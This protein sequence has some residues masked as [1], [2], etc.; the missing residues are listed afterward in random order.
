MQTRS[1]GA[2][3]SPASQ[4]IRPA[5]PRTGRARWP[6][7]AGS[8]RRSRAPWRAPRRS[9]MRCAAPP[10]CRPRTPCR[11]AAPAGG[12]A[13]PGS[14]HRGAPGVVGRHHM[15]RHAGHGPTAAASPALR[16]LP[17]P[18]MHLRRLAI[19]H[20]QRGQPLIVE[21]AKLEYLPAGNV[22]CGAGFEPR[23][24]AESIAHQPRTSDRAGACQASASSACQ[25][26]DSR[27]VD[28][29]AVDAQPHCRRQPAAKASG[30]A[31]R[32]GDSAALGVGIS[33]GA[34]VEQHRVGAHH[35]AP[36]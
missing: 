14:R 25:A 22:G 24:R 16:V 10:R 19:E 9:R 32:G 5:A 30:T 13:A 18:V 8:R 1:S 29:T 20:R 12:R 21:G 34:G 15:H 31:R 7:R 33:R 28:L 27:I 6:R 11:D 26:C 2:G 36:D 17:S 23:C 4:S 3:R 35:S